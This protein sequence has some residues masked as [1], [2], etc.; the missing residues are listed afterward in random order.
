M[1]FGLIRPNNQNEQPHKKK[2]TAIK[3]KTIKL[4][5]PLAEWEAMYK[6]LKDVEANP[7]YTIGYIVQ[8]LERNKK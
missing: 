7:H 5:I 1:F 4:E 6:Q 3:L 2:K 8:V